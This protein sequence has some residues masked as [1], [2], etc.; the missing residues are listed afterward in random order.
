MP[1]LDLY[2]EKLQVTNLTTDGTLSLDPPL[3]GLSR[4]LLRRLYCLLRVPPISGARVAYLDSGAPVTIFPHK[5]WHDHFCWQAGRDFD[6]L[7]IAGAPPLTG[8]VL[9]RRYTCRLARLR[10]AVELAGRD[11]K[12]DRI[13][14]DSMV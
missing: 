7:S 1:A 3:P 10:V 9:G 13:R 8:Q 5:I 14:L 2:I 6:E 12:G 11:P 4:V